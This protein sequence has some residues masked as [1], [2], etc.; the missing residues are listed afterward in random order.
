MSHPPIE[1]AD[2]VIPT[3]SDPV[4]RAASTAIGGPWGRH[5]VVGR[6]YFWTPLRVCLAL[7]LAVLAA[8]WVEKSPCQSGVWTD[9]LQYTHLCYSDIIP[10][11]YT[12]GLDQGKIPYADH[13][14]EYP[15]LTGWFMYAAASISHGYDRL[16][17]GGYLPQLNPVQS[18]YEVT[19]LLLVCCALVYLWS[20]YHLTGRRSWDTAM[21]ALSP[22]LFVHAFTNWDLLVVALA[23]GALLAWQRRVPWLAG[24][25]IGLG[26]AAKFYPVL[27]LW[28]LLLV[29]L[30]ARR[31]REFG[32]TAV[33]A[34]GSWGLLNG[35]VALLWPGSWRE[36]FTLNQTRGADP[37]S[38]WNVL[39]YLRGVP[40]DQGLPAGAAPTILNLSVAVSLTVVCLAIGWLAL[41]APRRPR[42][43]QLLFLV[44]AGFLLTNKVWSP[45][46]SLW[47]VPLAVLALPSWRALLAWQATEALLWF[48]RMYWYLGTDHKGVDEGWF[49]AAV[50]LR[51]VAV[52]WLMVLV[53]RQVLRP[54]R[55]V[56]RLGGEDD[57][58]GGVV[59]G[60]PDRGGG[61]VEVAD[62][63]PVR[64]AAVRLAPA[65]DPAAEPAGT[66]ESEV[67]NR[68]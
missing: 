19:V 49:L 50:V 52:V 22:V 36:F 4:V 2:R 58:I 13:A 40:L 45:Q 28:P 43:A 20:F 54:E 61:A 38:L 42:L 7:L 44:V 31:M 21:V 47:L 34:A 8:S 53:V 17:S 26:A 59:D 14:V 37:D 51:D 64:G 29:C 10:L 35:P 25:L 27:F 65:P 18:Y 3:W 55:D 24:L 63:Y 16:A 66:T 12:E 46:Y 39:R 41:A 30:R 32:T 56:V 9:N 23:T 5:A 57:P 62:G 6:A 67:R 1:D 48:P 33:F 60:A 68:T 15:V 11:Y